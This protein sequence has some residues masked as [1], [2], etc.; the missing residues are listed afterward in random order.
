MPLIKPCL[1]MVKRWDESLGFQIYS[2]AQHSALRHA[3]S[4][5]TL[6][7]DEGV[8]M[9]LPILLGMGHFLTHLGHPSTFGFCVELLGDILMCCVIEMGL[10]FCFGRD[11]PSYAKQ[12]T[13]YILPGEWWSFPSGHAMRAAFVTERLLAD[14]SLFATLFGPYLA[15]SFVAACILRLWAGFVAWSRVAKGR[16][17]PIDVIVGLGV[18]SIVA[19]IPLR[20]GVHAWCIAKLFAGSTTSAEAAV[21]VARPDLRLEGLFVHL[22]FQILWWAMQPFGLGLEITGMQVLGIAASISI[23]TGLLGALHIFPP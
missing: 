1:V 3:A 14:S 2:S 21:M 16:H 23:V 6:S 13:F 18:G 22:A 4:I 10:K 7:G 15:N 19:R 5:L 12:G 20:I 11:R 8:W 17:S 9:A